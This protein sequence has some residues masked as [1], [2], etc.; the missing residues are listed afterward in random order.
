MLKYLV[1]KM[2]ISIEGSL[3]DLP[4]PKLRE[5]RKCEKVRKSNLSQ[6][7]V[8]KSNLSQED[9]CHVISDITKIFET[10]H[11]NL[12]ELKRKSTEKFQ[13]TDIA[14]LKTIKN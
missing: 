8:R 7:E 3:T 5:T 4:T 10:V 2:V 1:L 11:Y 14:S 6:E 13:E 9:V 12:E